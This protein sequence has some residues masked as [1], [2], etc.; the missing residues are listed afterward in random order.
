[1]ESV[2]FKYYD[3]HNNIKQKTATLYASPRQYPINGQFVDVLG[4]TRGSFKRFEHFLNK[5]AKISVQN[6]LYPLTRKSIIMDYL[7]GYYNSLAKNRLLQFGIVNRQGTYNYSCVRANTLTIGNTLIEF[8][9]PDIV[10]KL[11][12]GLNIFVQVSDSLV[13]A[14]PL[15]ISIINDNNHLLKLSANP[16]DFQYPFSA[17]E[18]T[19]ISDRLE[20]YVGPHIP[21]S[22]IVT[23][24]QQMYFN[25]LSFA[26]MSSLDL[27]EIQNNLATL[28]NNLLAFKIPNTLS[29]L[30]PMAGSSIFS[31][32]AKLASDCDK[33]IVATTFLIF[34]FVNIK[35]VVFTP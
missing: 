2:S 4:F 17:I 9:P 22:N 33:S 29:L 19:I 3:K 28:Y 7:T 30:A 14:R 8:N 32:F 27:D 15:L 23:I 13:E 24:I 18:K 31:L 35:V 10:V 6:R 26:F 34:D 1:M 5:F 21:R 12:I 20:N 25:Y 11:T 16:K